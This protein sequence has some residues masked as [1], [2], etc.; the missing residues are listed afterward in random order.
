MGFGGGA[1]PFAKSETCFS[2]E[3]SVVTRVNRQ[4]LLRK[5]PVGVP[6]MEDFETAETAVGVPGPGEVLL[7][8]LYL[9][10]DPAIRGWMS[11]ARSYLPPIALG[12]PIRSGTLSQIAASND[13]AWPEGQLVQALAAWEWYS[14]VP[15]SSLHGRVVAIEIQRA[16]TGPPPR[17]AFPQRLSTARRKRACR[18]CTP[19]ATRCRRPDRSCER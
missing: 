11:D 12:A 17:V 6:T 16:R 18:R 8:N 7:K 13:D 15:S 10:I 3:G 14:V 2:L 4:I 19:Y 5:R 9:S 1:C